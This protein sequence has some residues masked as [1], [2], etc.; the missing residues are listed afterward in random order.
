M[1]PFIIIFVLLVVDSL[2]FIFARL[3]HPHSPPS[4]SVLFVLGVATLEVGLYGLVAKRLDWGEIKAKLWLFAAIGVLIAASTTINYQ[5][6][7][8]IDPGIASVLA[9][10]G[11][12]W[13]VLFGL[14]WLKETLTS[15]QI[16]G[17][18]LAMVGVFIV[19]FQAGDYVRVGSLL[20][21]LSAALY[22]LHAALTKKF[23]E[24]I[25]L[26]NFFFARLVFS[27]LAIFVFTT[28]SG[29][30]ALPGPAAWPFIVLA[31]TI[32]VA[33]SRTLYYL[34]LR[35]LKLT[36]H[37]IL[38]TLSPVIAILWS[39]ALFDSRITTQQSIGGIIVL[40]GVMLV[41]LFREKLK[42]EIS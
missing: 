5:A 36:V 39:I 3:L 11:T 37:T 7:E 20:V 18:V 14:V 29:S 27:T 41:A 24:E 12:V 25:D 19:N 38:L 40:V 10:T 31:G 42:P 1:P 32:D 4:V 9:Q 28:L 34:A 26:V 35:R 17:A 23:S 15:V 33:V 8:F 2:H 21:I 16:F 6:V 22:A 13:A 30:L